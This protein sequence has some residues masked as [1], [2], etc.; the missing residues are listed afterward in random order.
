MSKPEKVATAIGLSIC[1]AL[2]Y[3]E[4]G[5]CVAFWMCALSKE[6]Q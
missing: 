3:F 5:I 2:G 4:A 1:H 6:Q